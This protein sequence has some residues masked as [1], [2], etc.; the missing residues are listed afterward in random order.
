M[1]VNEGLP[2]YMIEN[3]RRKMDIKGKKIGILGMAFK[4]NVDDIRE[5]LSFKLGKILKFHGAKVYYSDPFVDDPYYISTEQVI[6]DCEIVFIGVPHDQYKG[7]KFPKTTYVIDIWKVTDQQIQ[8]KNP[9]SHEHKHE[10]PM[11]RC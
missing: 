10:K 1:L 3:L 2:N 6:K 9:H 8:E 7:L 11:K 5:S 4:A